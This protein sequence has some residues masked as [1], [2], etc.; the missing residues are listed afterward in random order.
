MIYR[1]YK[2]VKNKTFL[3]IVNKILVDT[4]EESVDTLEGT[5][6]DSTKR[7][8]DWVNEGYEYCWKKIF[9]TYAFKDDKNFSI[10]PHYN[11]N[12][13]CDFVEIRQSYVTSFDN[14]LVDG[15]ELTF[16]SPEEFNRRNFID[17]GVPLYYTV[18]D[19]K[20][21]FKPVPDK[22]YEGYC[23][24][25]AMLCP[26]TKNDDFPLVN[27]NLLV[28]YGIFKQ[29]CLDYN[30]IDSES[31]AV[32]EELLKTEITSLA[33]TRLTATQLPSIKV[34]EWYANE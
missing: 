4:D 33:N 3:E 34:Q 7:V 6:L 11:K 18:F 29:Y 19:R 23:M 14:M 1:D 15:K 22:E 25:T 26:L 32:F 28:A 13:D 12:C 31:W 27:A 30:R 9:Q 21:L 16:L 24:G 8:M 2:N 17:K 10:G 5:I 20:I